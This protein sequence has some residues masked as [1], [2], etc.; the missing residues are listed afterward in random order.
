MSVHCECDSSGEQVQPE[1]QVR[2]DS[3]YTCQLLVQRHSLVDNPIT[4]Q[5]LRHSMYIH[6]KAQEHTLVYACL[7]IMRL[8]LSKGERLENLLL[9]HLFFFIFFSI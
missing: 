3:L 9:A 5:E 2:L 7:F 6:N 1:H 8:R 4:P